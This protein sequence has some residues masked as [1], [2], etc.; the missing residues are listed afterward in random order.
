[1]WYRT[2]RRRFLGDIE[3]RAGPDGWMPLIES[4]S[5]RSRCA[6]QQ[7]TRFTSASRRPREVDIWLIFLLKEIKFKQMLKYHQCDTLMS[8]LGNGGSRIQTYLDLSSAKNNSATSKSLGTEFKLLYME[9]PKNPLGSACPKSAHKLSTC[10]SPCV[11][12]M[13]FPSS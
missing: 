7:L 6:L 2:C 13:L 3:T 5:C 11:V 1:M 4:A 12:V 10:D 8:Q 9:L